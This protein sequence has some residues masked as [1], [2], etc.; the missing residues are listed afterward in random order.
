MYSLRPTPNQYILSVTV[1]MGC[2][3]ARAA[4]SVVL[5]V[6]VNSTN[7]YSCVQERR[8]NRRW[9]ITTGAVMTA[10]GMT[11]LKWCGWSRREKQLLHFEEVHFSCNRARLPF[12]IY[13]QFVKLPNDIHCFFIIFWFIFFHLLRR[14]LMLCLH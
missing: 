4:T 8:V 14:S 11:L 6:H 10:N 9:D 7:R 3:T 5:M 12:K 13:F 2:R 1:G